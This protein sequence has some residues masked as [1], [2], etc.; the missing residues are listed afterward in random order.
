MKKI[1]FILIL[2][3]V[4]LCSFIS[5]SNYDSKF[6]EISSVS[7]KGYT[8]NVVYMNRGGS[9]NR[10]KSKYFASPTNSSVPQRFLNFS[11]NKNMIMVSSAGYMDNYGVPVGLTIDNGKLVNKNLGSTDGLII[12]YPTGGI[13]ATDIEKGDLTLQGGGIAPGRKFDI[14]NSWTDRN[15]FIK[16]AQSQ[17][18]T[19]FQ[20][21]LLVYKDKLSIA[22]NAEPTKRERRFLAVG[23]DK[24]SG[25]LC[26]AILNL[27][28]YTSLYDGTFRAKKF[29]NDTGN[30]EITFMINLDTGYQDVCFLY[31]KDASINN[32]IHGQR[33]LDY[34]V[35]LLAYYYE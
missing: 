4:F 35:N 8:Y 11:E 12:V 26:H 3:I 31:N 7:E 1:N 24:S 32:L 16:W 23:K 15:D 30:M 21:H 20:T 25:D 28:E 18:A 6:V 34:A 5:I 17:E 29:L 14:R 13:V 19:V 27:P 9:K 33:S 2:G 10:I 22:T